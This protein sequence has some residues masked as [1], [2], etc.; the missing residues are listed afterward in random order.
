MKIFFTSD[1][2]FGHEN[3]LRHCARPFASAEEMDEAMIRNWNAVVGPEDS[4]WHLGDFA[5]NKGADRLRPYLERLNG[6]IHLV[7]GNH[8]RRTPDYAALFASTQDL[9]EVKVQLPS[10][11]NKAVVLCHYAMRERRNSFRGAWHFYGHSHGGL[12]D[13]ATALSLDIGVDCWGFRP[14]GVEEL[15]R[16]MAHKNWTPLYGSAA[17]ALTARKEEGGERT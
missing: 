17:K 15:E 9:A 16:R 6:T 8:D 4:V 3:I 12:A 13:D 14:V 5:M 11:H 1:T 2:H 7:L 10:G